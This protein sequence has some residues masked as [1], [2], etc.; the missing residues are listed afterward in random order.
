[1]DN[2]GPPGP[3]MCS[4]YSWAKFSTFFLYERGSNFWNQLDRL[5]AAQN[6][7]LTVS[8]ERIIK[9]ILN[10]IHLEMILKKKKNTWVFQIA[11]QVFFFLFLIWR[12]KFKSSSV[13]FCQRRTQS[14]CW[15]KS[16]RASSWVTS[17]R[18]LDRSQRGLCLPGG[19]VAPW[20]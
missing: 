5:A 10:K 17:S 9:V 3:Q 6:Y 20:W 12:R 11:W 2:F 15:D 19:T 13:F 1:M 8:C 16:L 14:K 7:S 18:K 4:Y